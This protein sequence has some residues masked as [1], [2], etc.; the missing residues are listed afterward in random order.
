M[1]GLLVVFPAHRAPNF[2]FDDSPSS[3]IASAILLR[4][5][6]AEHCGNV[7]LATPWHQA[8]AWAITMRRIGVEHRPMMRLTD[9]TRPQCSDSLRICVN[10][11][12]CCVTRL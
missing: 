12:S 4:R 2:V 1:R 10:Q 3:S 6:V 11:S 7:Y 5:S 8:P 9:G